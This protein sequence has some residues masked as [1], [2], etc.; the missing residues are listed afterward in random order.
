MQGDPDGPPA[1]WDIG[2]VGYISGDLLLRFRDPRGILKITRCASGV[3]AS[4]ER[5]CVL[6]GTSHLAGRFAKRKMVRMMSG[7]PMRANVVPP[8]RTAMLSLV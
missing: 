8:T 1:V 6:L 2:H 3:L 7:S 5:D 4:H